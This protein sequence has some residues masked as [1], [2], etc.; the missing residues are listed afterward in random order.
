M[1]PK[2]SN[3]IEAPTASTIPVHCSHLRLADV[4]TLV[5]NPRNPNK[6]SDKQVALLA[7]VIQHQGWRSPI[8][9]SKRSGF[10]VTGHGRLAAALLLQV[11]FVPVDEQDFATE[12]DEW[13][14]LVADNR[15]AELA[16]AD[17]TMIADL[18]G[19]LDAGGLDMDLTGFDMEALEELLAE[20]NPPNITEDEV[21]DVPVDPI[22]KPDDL[23]ILGEHRVLCGDS[24]NAEDVGR[25]MAGEKWRLCVTSPPYNQKLDSFKASGMHTETKWVKNVQHGSYFDSKPESEYQSEQIAAVKVWMEQSSVDASI[26]YNH[27]NRYREKQVVSPW[28]W[29]SQTGL[30]VRQEI[31]WKREGSVTQNARMFMPC[32]ERIFWLYCGDDFYFN[33]ST[34]HKTWSSVWQINS[35][36]DRE[37]SMHGCAFPMELASRP[38]RACSKSGDV[39]LEPYCGSG[40]TLIAA[41]QLGRKCY[42]IEISPAYC[43]VI[44]KRWENL[45]GKQAVL[46]N[47]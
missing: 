11:E 46:C 39:V 35:H 37:E 22:T 3:P 20:T 16:D 12:A 1:K 25:L 24:T 26:F 21:P 8:T 30:K 38:I 43:D 6:H 2:K 23:W 7:K 28:G 31:I 41:E 47:E 34:E 14:H 36:K 18:L 42:G 5:A 9:I 10:V 33:D 44:V 40:T 15:L 32:D 45:T 17:R 27:K 4:T 19:E 13:A 29:L